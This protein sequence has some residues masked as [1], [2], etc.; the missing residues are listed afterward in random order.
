MKL[1]INSRVGDTYSNA[2]IYENR[3][4]KS[5][6][7]DTDKI[8]FVSEIGHIEGSSNQNSYYDQASMSYKSKRKTYFFRFIY[9]DNGLVLMARSEEIKEITIP[10]W[11]KE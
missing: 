4:F 3:N 10:D 9:F 2:D 1:R 8:T 7:I 6:I 5:Y 11:D